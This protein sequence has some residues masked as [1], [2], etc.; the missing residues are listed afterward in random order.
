MMSPDCY[1]LSRFLD[2]QIGIYSQVLRGLRDGQKQ[3]HWMWFV[4]PQL[5]GLGSS[6]TAQKYAIHSIDEANAYLEHPVLG[7]R[8]RE[9]T[10]LVNAIQGRPVDGIFSFPD[11]LKFQSCMTLFAEVSK[12]TIFIDALNKYFT[13][14]RDRK[15]LVFL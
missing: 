10:Q 2:A 15:T 7:A 9:C 11:N 8:L 6:P 1:S 5:R 12:E 14:E 13:G 3:S 4:F